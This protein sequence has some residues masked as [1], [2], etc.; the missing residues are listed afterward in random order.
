MKR[1]A[2]FLLSLTLALIGIEAASG[3]TSLTLNITKTPTIGEPKVTL[4]GLFKPARAN[5]KVAIQV[6]LNGVWTKT[7]LGAK[8]KSSGSWKIEV[9]S[10]ALAGSATY[11]FYYSF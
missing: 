9:V 2:I 7:S 5:V 3:A 10:T 8:T 4:N 11:R 6:K 1:L